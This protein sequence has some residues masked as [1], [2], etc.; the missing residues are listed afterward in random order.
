[1]PGLTNTNATKVVTN[2]RDGREFD[3]ISDAVDEGLCSTFA[4]KQDPRR[5]TLHLFLYLTVNVQML[6]L[7]DD[8]SDF[9]AKKDK[10]QFRQYEDACDRVKKFYKEQHGKILCL[11]AT[12][13]AISLCSR[14]NHDRKTNCRI[15]HPG[16][17]QLQ[18]PPAC[19]HGHL[20]GYGDAQHPCG[21]VRP[22]CEFPRLRLQ[23]DTTDA[24][25]LSSLHRPACRRS[26]I[27]SKPLRRFAAMANPSG[28]K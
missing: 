10:A 22:R 17:N 26:N 11:I 19:P 1:M 28:C 21:R 8:E 14:D 4:A 5:L 2:T 18:E 9:D 23:V 3:E 24:T 12:V 25:L 20:G 7:W 15:Q 16:S 27:Y 13:H 6:K